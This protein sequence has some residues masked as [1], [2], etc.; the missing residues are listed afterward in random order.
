M[1]VALPIKAENVERI[2][3][4]QKEHYRVWKVIGTEL[5][6]DVDTLSV[7]EK[8]HTNDEDCLCAMIDSAKPAPTHEAMTKILQST[9]ITS[10][11]AG[12]IVWLII[13]IS[14]FPDPIPA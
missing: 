12:I 13:I 3:K 7:I 4:V 14:S 2:F 6:I 1:Y 5:G 9:N 8:N 10:A 11:I